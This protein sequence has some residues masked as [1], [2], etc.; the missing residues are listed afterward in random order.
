MTDPRLNELYP[1]IQF[2]FSGSFFPEIYTRFQLILD[3][4]DGFSVDLTSFG[5]SGY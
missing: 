5:D 4:S 1:L 2:L 3:G